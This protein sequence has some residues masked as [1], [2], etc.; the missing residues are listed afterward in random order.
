MGEISFDPVIDDPMV[1]AVWIDP[2]AR[3]QLAKVFGIC[4]PVNGFVGWIAAYPFV[5]GGQSAG[6]TQHQANFED[7]HVSVPLPDAQNFNAPILGHAA[8]GLVRHRWHALAVSADICD[9][10]A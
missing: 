8:G 1:T 5:A 9:F 6:D 3:L 7:I 10:R 4:A 2:D